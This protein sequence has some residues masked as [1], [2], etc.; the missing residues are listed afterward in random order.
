MQRLRNALRL[1]S[2]QLSAL[3]FVLTVLTT[4]VVL[5]GP[6][7]G[8]SEGDQSMP[9]A[10]FGSTPTPLPAVPTRH[11]YASGLEVNGPGILR[12]LSIPLVGNAIVLV[13]SWPRRL[14]GWVLAIGTLLMFAWLAI[15]GFSVGFLYVPSVLG[16][17]GGLLRFLEEQGV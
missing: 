6:M 17:G 4:L 16:M 2:F 14:R 12:P 13:L 7:Y 3:A 11:R 15:A 9:A 8:G 5:F 1:S 10:E